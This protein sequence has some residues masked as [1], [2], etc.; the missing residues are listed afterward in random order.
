MSLWDFWPGSAMGSRVATPHSTTQ[1]WSA[2][3]VNTWQAVKQLQVLC[4]PSP[5]KWGCCCHFTDEETNTQKL[6]G[7][8][9]KTPRPWA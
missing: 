4:L 7:T 9:I 8:V 5:R 6:E 3:K 1:G 2:G